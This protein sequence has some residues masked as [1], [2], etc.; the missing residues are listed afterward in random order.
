MNIREETAHLLGFLEQRP[1]RAGQ[2]I[3]SKL[4][5]ALEMIT[6]IESIRKERPEQNI[7]GELRICRLHIDAALGVTDVLQRNEK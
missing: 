6:W 5:V 1:Q 4:T 2:I 3:D 7:S